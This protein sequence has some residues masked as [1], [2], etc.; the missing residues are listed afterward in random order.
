MST[1]RHVTF[2]RRTRLDID[3]VVKE[4]GLAMLTTEVLVSSSADSNLQGSW[5]TTYAADDILM[6]SKMGLAC[7]A[8]VD[9]AAIQVGVV[10]QPHDAG[11]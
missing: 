4:I 3:D 7:L 6:V 5:E 8:A 1:G 10:S 11:P 9:L 2:V